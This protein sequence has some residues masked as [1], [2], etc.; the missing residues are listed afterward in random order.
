MKTNG[1]INEV[2][3]KQYAYI[4]KCCKHECVKN[5]KVAFDEDVF[6]DTLLKCIEQLN[7]K[8]LKQE[9]VIAYIISSFKTNILR[10]GQYARNSKKSDNDPYIIIIPVSEKNKID[11]GLV[12]EQ[13]YSVFETLE[14]DIFSDWL[15]GYTI[16]ELNEKY[17]IKNARYIIDQIKDYIKQYYTLADFK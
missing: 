16:K 2:I 1:T 8:E 12:K 13:L 6:H 14:A 15:E 9:D 11:I 5:N 17:E 7:N 10:D 4:L 3:E